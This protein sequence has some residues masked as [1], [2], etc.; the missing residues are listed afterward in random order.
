MFFSSSLFFLYDLRSTCATMVRNQQTFNSHFPTST[1]KL[2]SVLNLC[3]VTS[4][5][6]AQKKKA[7]APK[8]KQVANGKAD[9]K[10]KP[11]ASTNEAS[12]S[13]KTTHTTV[14]KPDQAAYHA[15]QDA[16]KK[17]IDEHQAKLVRIPPPSTSNRLA[18]CK[19]IRVRWL[20]D[21]AVGDRTLSRKRLVIASL[22]VGMNDGMRL[23]PNWTPFVASKDPT[24]PLVKGCS[25][26]SRTFRIRFR[27]RFVGT[28]NSHIF[29][30]S[31]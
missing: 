14:T 30:H 3:Q 16:L 29:A 2:S 4:L 13:S 17:E 18:R 10:P 24:R 15:E 9:P 23:G 11:A 25:S 8:A 19:F 31:A 22:R 7:M 21:D 26:R 20:T 27:T 28:E 5:E 6:C 1:L 12:E